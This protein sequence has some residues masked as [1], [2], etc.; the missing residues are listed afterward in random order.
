MANDPYNQSWKRTSLSIL[1]LLFL[2]LS[3]FFS[4]FYYEAGIPHDPSGSLNELE[5][6]VQGFYFQ[7][8]LQIYLAFGLI[9]CA[10]MFIFVLQ[11]CAPKDAMTRNR[12]IKAMTFHFSLHKATDV[13]RSC[14]RKLNNLLSNAVD[15]HWK[16]WF[17]VK[18]T[19]AERF[20]LEPKKTVRIG[21]LFWTW[22]NWWTRKLSNTYGIWLHS[23]LAI[24][25]ECQ[26]IVL[27]FSIVL[28]GFGGS[29]LARDADAKREE[30]ALEPDSNPLKEDALRFVPEGWVVKASFAFGGFFAISAGAILILVYMPSTVSTIM[31]LRSGKIATFDD[32]EQF[33]IYRQSADTVYYNVGNAIYGE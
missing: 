18:V 33:K 25:Q 11:I 21:G 10:F 7:L 15:L 4:L 12:I 30:L 29:T 16:D 14:T 31:A 8:A 1:W 2:T 27:L 13:K 22:R 28:L 17:G 5:R 19:A 6:L 26:I 20:V 9:L 23:R 24:A 3:S 32:P